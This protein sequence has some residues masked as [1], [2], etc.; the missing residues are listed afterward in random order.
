[1]SNFK[2]YPLQ[3]QANQRLVTPEVLHKILS[4]P[5]WYYDLKERKE[6]EAENI[7]NLEML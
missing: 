1:M 4:N 2:A 6:K 7:K 5:N 3:T